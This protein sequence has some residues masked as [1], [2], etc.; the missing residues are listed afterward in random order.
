MQAV[1]IISSLTRLQSNDAA[2][3]QS[4]VT[5]SPGRTGFPY[6]VSFRPERAWSGHP[7]RRTGALKWQIYSKI[8]WA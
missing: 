1:P 8:Q 4:V 3:A 6:P 5:R 2:G 7:L